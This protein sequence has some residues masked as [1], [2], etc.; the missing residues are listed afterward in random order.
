MNGSTVP[1][2]GRHHEFADATRILTSVLAPV[3]KRTLLWLANRMPRSI[4]S[5]HLTAL[6]LAAM[7]LAGLSYWLASV[8]PAGLL[9][10]T[11]CLAINW[12]GDSL[13]GTLARVRCQQRP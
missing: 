12:F 1:V 7:F 4:N 5:D 10:A 8:T 9:L 13:D 11:A 2:A 6:A 3:E